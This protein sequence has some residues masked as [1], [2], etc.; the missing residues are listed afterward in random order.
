MD[1]KDLEAKHVFTRQIHA[2]AALIAIGAKLRQPMPVTATLGTKG[3][4][5]VFWF[6]PAEIEC[7]GEKKSVGE[8]LELL[9]CPYEKFP[10]GPDHPISYLKAVDVNRQVL[11]TGVKTARQKPFRVVQRGRRIV[12]L[13]A[14]VSDERARQLI[15]QQ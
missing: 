4:E 15:N 8:W 7:G 9:T 2:A 3:E 5:I 12:V 1:G 14:D 10:L 11:L 6:E 13:G